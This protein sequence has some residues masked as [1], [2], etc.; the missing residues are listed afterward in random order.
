MIFKE[1]KE[2]VAVFKGKRAIAA[3]YRGSRLVW[4][5]IRSCFGTGYWVNKKSWINDEGWKNS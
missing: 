2:I 3:I 4:Q 5:A 1:E